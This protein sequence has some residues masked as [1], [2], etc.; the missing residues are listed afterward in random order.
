MVPS[1]TEQTRQNRCIISSEQN[2]MKK[3]IIIN[4]SWCLVVRCIVFYDEG[5][6]HNSFGRFDKISVRPPRNKCMVRYSTTIDLFFEV[7]S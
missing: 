6:H 2:L 7:A 1:G 5:H 3:E 4:L